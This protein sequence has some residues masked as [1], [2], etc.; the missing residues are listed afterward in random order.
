MT[1]LAIEKNVKTADQ[2]KKAR[3]L[4]V[5]NPDLK[6]MIDAALK[7]RSRNGKGKFRETEG[8]CPPMNACSQRL[9]PQ[10]PQLLTICRFYHLVFFTVLYGAALIVLATEFVSQGVQ[11]LVTM[12]QAL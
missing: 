4:A 5:D 3:E 6:L 11:T 1:Y 8:P 10:R 12:F 2:F 7:R 9:Y